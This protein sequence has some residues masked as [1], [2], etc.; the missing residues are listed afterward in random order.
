MTH[1]WLPIRYREFYDVPRAVVVE[2][3]GETY[4]FDCPF[5]H[6]IDDYLPEYTVY[7]L[8]PDIAD[9]LDTM[10]WADLGTLGTKVGS[11][12]VSGVVFD[13]TRRAAMSE[14]VFKR[15]GID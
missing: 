10:S 4:L 11:I 9:E 2:F 5:D 14:S 1:T 15:L 6:G 7:R 8:P 3:R 13:A 12:E